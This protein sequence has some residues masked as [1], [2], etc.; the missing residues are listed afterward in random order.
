MEALQGLP[1]SIDERVHQLRPHAGQMAS[2]VICAVFLSGSELVSS[3][4]DHRAQ[5]AYSL[6]CPPHGASH[7]MS[8]ICGKPGE[9]EI[10]SVTDNPIIFSDDGDV[11][12]A[13]IFMG[14]R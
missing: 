14:S 4:N 11:I 7:P 8:F 6:R 12:S 3:S 5:D 9:T 10:N 1:N 13:R 2:A